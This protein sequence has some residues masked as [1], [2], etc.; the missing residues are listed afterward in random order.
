[1]IKKFFILSTI[2]IVLFVF[3]S[4]VVTAENDATTE[5]AIVLDDEAVNDGE[6]VIVIIPDEP[7]PGAP[8]ATDQPE[9]TVTPEQAELPKELP[10]TGGCPATVLY[11]FGA[12]L[13]SAGIMLKKIENKNKK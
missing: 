4:G 3:G 11:G 5:A 10:R 9:A 2:L 12:F 8:A 1:M 7:I 6:G 13:S